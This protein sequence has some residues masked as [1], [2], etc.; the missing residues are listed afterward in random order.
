M[1][2]DDTVA[3]KSH[4]YNI[5]L[6]RRQWSGNKK[7]VIKGMGR[8]TCVY[9]NPDVDR[10]WIV[11]FRLY[12]PA[13]DGKGKPE[14][15][16]EMLL[17]NVYSKHLPFQTVLMDTWYASRKLILLIEELEKTYYCPIKSNRNVDDSDGQHKHKRVDKLSW[18]K[19]E[20][21]QGKE[22]HVKDFPKDHRVKLFRL[23]LSTK[24]TD[25]VITNDLT[26]NSASATR[27]ECDIRWGVEEFHRG[28]K[29][30]TGLEHCQY[31]KQRAQRNH[32][33]CSILV[34]V[35]LNKY[36]HEVSKTIYQLKEELLSDYMKKELEEPTLKMN[37][38]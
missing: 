16:R 15:A 2:F 36:A 21:E 24:R 17:H 10:F 1:I 25:Y 6:V 27:E 34:W 7:K 23:V 13:R 8:V 12:D 5:E 14:H 28:S 26:Q 11:D 3:D 4:S 9:V 18:S 20:K 37:L 31:R 19:E 33:T 22:V 30:L 35:Q 38:A 32:I 29:Q